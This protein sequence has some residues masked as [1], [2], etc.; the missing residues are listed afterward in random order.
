MK[1]I[2]SNAGILTNFEVLDFLRSRGAAKDPT[3]VIAPVSP[4]EYKVYDY[5]VQTTACNQSRECINDFVEKCKKYDLT[6][7]EIISIINTRPSSAAQMFTIIEKCS[8]RGMADI[9]E[10]LVEMVTQLLP[11]GPNEKLPEE[12][13]EEG[14]ENSEDGEQMDV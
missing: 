14:G 8:E 2:K 1:I 7:A 3:R 6:K 9:L 11:P 10:E 5:L 12:E 13:N 4:S